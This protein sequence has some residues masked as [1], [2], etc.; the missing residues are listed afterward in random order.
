MLT[1]EGDPVSAD[2]LLD[3]WPENLPYAAH[4]PNPSIPVF[5]SQSSSR[6][7]SGTARRWMWPYQCLKAKAGTKRRLMPAF[8]KA[9]VGTFLDTPSDQISGALRSGSYPAFAGDESSAAVR[10]EET[11][12]H[13]KIFPSG[14]RRG[15]RSVLGLGH[16]VRI[17]HAPIAASSRYRVAS[18]RP[19]RCYRVQGW[20]KSVSEFRRSAGR[21]LRARSSRLSRSEP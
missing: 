7:P 12:R 19:D 20:L 6:A 5:V 4:T 8:Y 3:E 9:S 1:F 2:Y 13:P 14:N 16:I 15:D 21:R 10:L 18:W 11:D 17:S